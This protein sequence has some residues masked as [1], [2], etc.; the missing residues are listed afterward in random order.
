MIGR[1]LA[2]VASLLAVTIAA[3]APALAG[4]SYW[5][6]D[7]AYSALGPRGTVR[8]ISYAP[9]IGFAGFSGT[10][11]SKGL[12]YCTKCGEVKFT[13]YNP[14]YLTKYP[15]EPHNYPAKSLGKSGGSTASASS[16]SASKK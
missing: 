6:I 7:C 15:T 1:S 16:S 13:T 9:S 11:I 14:D 8:S 12:I 4:N 10:S 2:V 3:P 5:D